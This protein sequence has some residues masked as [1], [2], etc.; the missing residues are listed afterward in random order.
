VI[1]QSFDEPL[2]HHSSGSEYAYLE[3]HC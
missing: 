1:L 2:P 3:F